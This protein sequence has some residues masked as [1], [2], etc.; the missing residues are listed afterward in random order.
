MENK[1]MNRE[2]IMDAVAGLSDPL[3]KERTQS[4]KVKQYNK[5][6]RKM[7]DIEL[8]YIPI[9]VTIE[10]FDKRFG[11][12]WSVE[13]LE[14]TMKDVS[15]SYM[16]E[17]RLENGKLDW[18]KLEQ[19]N[20]KVKNFPRKE[21]IHVT[22]SAAFVSLDLVLRDNE[23]TEI[24][25]RPGTGSGTNSGQRNLDS[26]K[27]TKTAL[28]NAI[29]KASNNYGF[30]IYLWHGPD[31]TLP[32]N[33]PEPIDESAPAKTGPSMSEI[34]SEKI[35]LLRE[36]HG[37]GKDD[38]SDYLKTCFPA[39]KGQYAFMKVDDENGTQD[40]KVTKFAKF[41]NDSVARKKQ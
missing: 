28:A 17:V 26:D 3:P 6:T 12:H 33:D 40:E 31:D 39:S 30:G 35:K 4:R 10:E 36:K 9:W 27:M 34:N 32:Q 11:T 5:D 25:R 29:R 41:I 21:R 19:Q 24:C 7:E 18:M 38:L 15:F 16:Q 1:S 8:T 2:Q 37:L 20:G 14:Q 13:N 23:G 22:E